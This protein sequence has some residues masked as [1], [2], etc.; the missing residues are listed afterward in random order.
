MGRSPKRDRRRSVSRERGDR[1]RDRRH[2]HRRSR[3][4]SNSPR[5]RSPRRRSHSNERDE[6]RTKHVDKRKLFPERPP[7]EE[8]AFEGKTEDEVEMMKLMGFEGFETSK[9]KKVDGN[10]TGVANVLRKRRYRQ[11]MNRRG[12]FNRPLDPIA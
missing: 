8:S 10:D 6:K 4:R 9:G 12:G 5:R 2:R 3:S 7:L 1:D 11:Y